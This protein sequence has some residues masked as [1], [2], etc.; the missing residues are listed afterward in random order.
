VITRGI[1]YER[2]VLDM[3]P[4]RI[5]RVQTVGNNSNKSKPH[6]QRYRGQIKVGECLLPFSSEFFIFASAIK[7]IK[8]Y[9]TVIL[10]AFYGAKLSSYIEGR[11]YV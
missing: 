1:T 4:S 7:N 8:I 2:E 9:K 5:L 3:T 10:V 11:K 6:S